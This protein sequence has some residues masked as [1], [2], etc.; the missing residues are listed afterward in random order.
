MPAWLALPPEG[1]SRAGYEALPEEVRRCLEVVDGA[2][3]VRPAPPSEHERVL[4]R[5]ATVLTEVCG[6]D[7]EVAIRVDLRLRER[8]LLNRRPDLVVHRSSRGGAPAPERCILITEVVSRDSATVDRRG[9]PVQYAAA[10]VPPYWR[11]EGVD[12]GEVSL[13]RYRLDPTTRVYAPAGV[14]T[15]KATVAEPFAVT[16]DLAALL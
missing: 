10:G 15:G 5:L 2:V 13:F 7:W 1:L 16:L 3:V 4:G 8:P 11:V 6:P 12:R 9:K 14:D